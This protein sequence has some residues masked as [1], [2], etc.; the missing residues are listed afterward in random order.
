MTVDI[1]V[2]IIGIIFGLIGAAFFVKGFLRM[3]PDVIAELAGTRT[4]YSYHQLKDMCAQRAYII[5]GFILVIIGGL[6]EIA[7]V[8]VALNEKIPLKC[9][10]NIAIIGF[11]PMALVAYAVFHI[12]CDLMYTSTLKKS[13][14]V[15]AKRH[16]ETRAKKKLTA[17]ECDGLLR[18][19]KLLLNERKQKGETKAA[20]IK[21]ILTGLGYEVDDANL[22]DCKEDE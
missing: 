14:T 17:L 6:T 7:A 8:V 11:I 1:Y 22:V 5:C 10:N 3:T 20:F 4:G 9:Q 12:I 16:F 19:I 21:R 18:E 15:T 13:S 2:S